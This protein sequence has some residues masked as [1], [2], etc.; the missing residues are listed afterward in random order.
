[1]QNG[2]LP[3]RSAYHAR[4]NSFRI[5]SPAAFPFPFIACRQTAAPSEPLFIRGISSLPFIDSTKKPAASAGFSC[6]F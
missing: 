2:I 5:F 4:E 3:L 6:Y 1:M